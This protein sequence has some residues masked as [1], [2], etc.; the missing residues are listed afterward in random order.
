MVQH[1]A[2]YWM[3]IAYK[4]ALK[5]LDAGEVPV[6]AV[7][8]SETGMLLGAGCNRVIQDADPTAHA[9]VI[10]IRQAAKKCGNYR[11]PHTTLYVTLEPC[12]LC[13]S[14]LIQARVMRVV[15]AVR[16]WQAGAAGSH[17]NLLNGCLNHTV[18]I[19]EGTLHEECQTL[20]M[21]FFKQRRS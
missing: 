15:F 2:E 17:C 7:L 11:L 1:N 5:A 19:D 8:V 3:K 14:T 4:E 9:E 13:A 16:D 12:T 21:N 10:A 6:G 20:L 18:Q